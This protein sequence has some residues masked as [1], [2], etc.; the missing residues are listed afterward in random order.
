MLKGVSL[1][2]IETQYSLTDVLNHNEALD[3]QEAAEREAHN[4]A[5]ER[6]K[7]DG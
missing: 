5:R 1:H 4:R 7:D 3:L 2:A 6:M